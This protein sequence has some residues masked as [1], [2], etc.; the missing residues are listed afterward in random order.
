MI[1]KTSPK[2]VSRLI[3]TDEN[4]TQPVHISFVQFFPVHQLIGT[5]LGLG[6]AKFGQKTGLDRTFKH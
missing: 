3:K 1:W 5:G 4:C 2:P 6:L